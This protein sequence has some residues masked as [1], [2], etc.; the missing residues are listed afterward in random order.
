MKYSENM[1]KVDI[2]IRSSIG[3]SMTCSGIWQ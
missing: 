2:M 3:N 1:K